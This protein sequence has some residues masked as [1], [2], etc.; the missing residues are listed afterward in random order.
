MHWK[1]WY[2]II[3]WIKLTI[4]ISAYRCLP[5]TTRTD[6]K[7]V[8]VSNVTKT[9]YIGVTANSVL[10]DISCVDLPNTIGILRGYA[11]RSGRRSEGN[12][13]PQGG[14]VSA[15]AADVPRDVCLTVSRNH[16]VFPLSSANAYI[17]N[18]TI[19][20]L[21]NDKSN[22]LPKNGSTTRAWRCQPSHQLDKVSD[23]LLWKLM[24]T[25]TS[26]IWG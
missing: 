25:C 15:P 23:I 12:Q 3:K 22:D 6:E 21:W 8:S 1:V 26:T 16:T 9:K 13:W 24:I 5:I 11:I 7:V 18:T 14:P 2:S 20:K 4:R 10:S 19:V 17:V